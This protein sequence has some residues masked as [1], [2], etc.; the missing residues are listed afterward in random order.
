[1]NA[2]AHLPGIRSR[3]VATPRGSFHVLESGD[4]AGYPVVFL[5]GNLASSTF[6]EEVMLELPAGCCGFAPDLRGYGESEELPVDARNGMGDF[7]ADI[8]T[9][10]GV[11][12]LE[13]FH[14]VG[15]S[16]GGCVAMDYTSKHP[17][18][19]RSLSLIASGSPFGFGGTKDVHGTPC[20]NDYAGSG[21]GLINPE[22]LRRLAMQDRSDESDFSPIRMLTRY[23]VPV[24]LAPRRVNMLLEA[25]LQT[26]TSADNYS[27]D[28]TMSRNWP[29]FAPGTRGV[30]N[31][32]SPKYCNLGGL[33]DIRPAP[34]V[35][36][37]RGEK[38]QVVSDQALSD[39]GTLG[40]MGIIPNWPGAEVFPS[41][42]M[43]GQ[44][45]S[46]LQRYQAN[47]G[48]YTETV[49]PGVGHSPYLE[50]TRAFLA[51][52]LPFVQ[53]HL[54]GESATHR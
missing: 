35:F 16:L 32:L 30:N 38:D 47:G 10:F 48:S 27:R 37:L 2:L 20:W 36:W 9:L 39:V 51:A 52:W 44:I 50:D 22:W 31:A 13:S 5:H 23:I 11:L 15:H 43:V 45:R 26:A 42:P 53:Q 49:L 17:Q 34:P 54:A 4:P 3:Q 7:S 28:F 14:L 24:P 1:M 33:A 25:M 41:Q 40:A 12:G 8:H 18:R 21:G 46:M 29:G 6:W 19:V